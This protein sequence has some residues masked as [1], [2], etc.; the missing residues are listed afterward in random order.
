MT[1]ID[2]RAPISNQAVN[3]HIYGDAYMSVHTNNKSVELLTD[4]E[5]MILQRCPTSDR[6]CF[7]EPIDFTSTNLWS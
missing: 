1:H 3:Q 7:S 2:N 5:F 4:V 6:Y